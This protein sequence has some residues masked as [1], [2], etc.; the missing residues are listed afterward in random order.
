M[1]KSG[2]VS[3]FLMGSTYGKFSGTHELDVIIVQQ[4]GSPNFYKA[5]PSITLYTGSR[6]SSYDPAIARDAAV[7]PQTASMETGGAFRFSFQF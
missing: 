7:A 6:G 4:V 5:T 3:S 1:M 2:P